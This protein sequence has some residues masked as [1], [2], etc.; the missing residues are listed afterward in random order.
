MIG[1]TGSNGKTTTKELLHAVMQEKFRTYA[2]KGNLN[3][4]IGVPLT[5]LSVDPNAEYA[6]VE[7]GANH[8]GE[9]ADLC[10]IA[11]PRIGLIT[12]IGRA[13]LEGFGGIEGVK[14]AKGELYDYLKEHHGKIFF[15]ANDPILCNLIG[16]YPNTLAYN[17]TQS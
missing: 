2:T 7:M 4:H 3:N 6:I 9:I 16:K 5:L 15:N 1:L 11:Q 17:N 12:N 10:S 8:Q 13:H 14:K